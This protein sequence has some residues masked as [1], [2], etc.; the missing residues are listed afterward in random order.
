MHAATIQ[1]S[2]G[3]YATYQAKKMKIVGMK[4]N[5]TANSPFKILNPS[6]TPLQRRKII[7]TVKKPIKHALSNSEKLQNI[8]DKS[9]HTLMSATTVFPFVLFPDTIHIDRQK[10]TIVHRSSFRSAKTISVSLNDI[11]NVESDVGPLFGSLILTSK[12][13]QNNIQSISFLRRKDAIKAQQLLQGYM[14]AKHGDI[15]FSTIPTSELVTLLNEL[16]KG[17]S[18]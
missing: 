13:F 1:N 8:V 11:Q 12:Y 3:S 9:H 10:L 14:V 5:S 2:L 17:S 4:A 18:Y 15:N 6:I 16:G 7:Q